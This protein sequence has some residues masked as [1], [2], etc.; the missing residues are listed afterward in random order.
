[1]KGKAGV[2]YIAGM[3]GVMQSADAW[4]ISVTDNEA[5]Q[6]VGPSGPCRYAVFTNIPEDASD[7]KERYVHATESASATVQ[8]AKKNPVLEKCCIR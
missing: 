3:S 4:T 5:L 8:I 2:T 6:I 1:M 7:P